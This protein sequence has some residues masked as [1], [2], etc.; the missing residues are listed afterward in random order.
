M[1]A[2]SIP[3]ARRYAGLACI[4]VRSRSK[5]SRATGVASKTSASWS[6]LIARVVTGHLVFA[7]L[8]GQGPPDPLGAPSCPTPEALSRF[9]ARTRLGRWPHDDPARRAG[10]DQAGRDRPRLPPLGPTAG[11][12]RH[13]AAH[14]RGPGGGHLRRAR[15]RVVAA[16]RR[17]APL[18]R[19]EPLRAQGGGHLP[20]R[21]SPV[22]DRA[23]ARW[24]RP[25]GGP[26]RPGAGHGGDR[27][28]P[29]LAGQAGPG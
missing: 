18:G 3:T 28:D 24:R 27:A 9:A 17:R 29:R 7:P 23:A 11:Q 20:R 10:G 6:A 14:R 12:G 5:T 21:P 19:R 8:G 4:I 13:T 26:A 16:S 25:A 22:A 2:R 15:R 1:S